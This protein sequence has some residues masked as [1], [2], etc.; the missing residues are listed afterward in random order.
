MMS[1]S[2]SLLEPAE[3]ASTRWLR[4]GLIALS[5]L[6]GAACLLGWWYFEHLAAE[7]KAE[8]AAAIAETDALDPDCRWDALE[9]KRPKIPDAENSIRVIR[10]AARPLSAATINNLNSPA[11]KLPNGQIAIPEDR[12]ANRQLDVE[13]LTEIQSCLEKWKSSVALAGSLKDFPRGRPSVKLEPV[14]FN[15]LLTDVDQSRAL[16]RLIELEIESLVHSDRPSKAVGRIQAMLHVGTARRDDPFAISQI[17]RMKVHLGMVRATERILGMAVLT[18]A[19][20]KRLAE[21]FGSDSSEDLLSPAIRGERAAH[22]KQ[23]DD[24]ETGKIDLADFIVKM[25]SPGLMPDLNLRIGAV[26]YRPRIYED[27]AQLLRL[28]NQ[29]EQIAKLPFHEQAA[30]WA[31]FHNQMQ[32]LK[33]EGARQTRWIYSVLLLPAVG[34]IAAAAQRDRALIS[35]TLAAL[36]AE[37]FRLANKR[38]PNKLDELCPQFLPKVLVDPYDGKPLRLANRDDGIVI[39]SIGGDGEDNGGEPLMPNP[40]PTEPGDLGIRLWN[41]DRRRLPPEPKKGSDPDN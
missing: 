31:A 19:D 28:M 26:F 6:I 17:V 5:L 14:L 12:L 33:A 8:L 20:L 25:S 27:H 22:H 39:Y 40:T 41:P 30:E 9:A 23:F 4:R 36:A 18:D 21:Y 10:E 24:I 7:G 29:C 11:F 13:L 35:C 34:K 37:R 38:W 15:T 2:G 3:T 16:V 1:A 32:A